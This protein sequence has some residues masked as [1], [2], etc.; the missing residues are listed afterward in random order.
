MSPTRIPT[1]LRRQVVMAA[2]GRCAYCR[3][4]EALMGVTF[5]VDHILP[6]AAGG[7]TTAENLCLCCP[8]CNRQSSPPNCPRPIHQP[9]GAA[10]SPEPSGMERAFHLEGRWIARSGVD[11]GGSSNG[12]GTAHESLTNGRVALLLGSDRTAP[13]GGERRKSPMRSSGV[14]DSQKAT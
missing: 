14:Q 2:Q 11:G 10:F 1:K 8:V 13:T 5:E 9:R 7:E 4:S 12:R 6:K 3:S